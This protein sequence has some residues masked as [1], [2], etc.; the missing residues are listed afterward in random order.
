MSFFVIYESNQIDFPQKHAYPI[1]ENQ[2]IN[3]KRK[4][5]QAKV[6]TFRERE[7]G[8]LQVGGLEIYI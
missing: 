5:E 3:I 8:E 2:E 6:L 4:Q 7:N 1:Q